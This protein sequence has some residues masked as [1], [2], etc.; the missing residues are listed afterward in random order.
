MENPARAVK[1]SLERN[2]F[3]NLTKA[4]E[5]LDSSQKKNNHLPSAAR[6]ATISRDPRWK[7]N[8]RAFVSLCA[9]TAR[10][11]WGCT[12]EN[13]ARL[14]TSSLHPKLHP[15]YQLRVRIQ[16][17]LVTGHFCHRH[18]LLPRICTSQRT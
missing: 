2:Y 9:C 15:T 10:T 6:H 7:K 5:E 4:L 8:I 16:H 17:V 13:R 11:R 12:C 1:H 18:R 3:S 14:S